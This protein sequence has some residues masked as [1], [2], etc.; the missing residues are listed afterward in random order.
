MAQLG[1]N[2][3]ATIEYALRWSDDGVLFEDRY[4]ARR[5]NV[6]RDIFPTGLEEKLSGCRVDDSIC[7]DYGPGQL[8]PPAREA[9]VM[10]LPF[11]DFQQRTISGRRVTPRL[12][13]FYPQ[14]M[15]QGV[16]GVFPGTTAPFRI[17]EMDD[18]GIVAD[19]N[20]PLARYSLRLEARVLQLED[21]SSETGGRLSHWVEELCNWGPG[22]QAHLPGAATD[23]VDEAF[24]D[25]IDT[26]ADSVFYRDPRFI[27]H[28]DSQASANLQAIYSRDLRP[29]MRVLDLMSSVESHLPMETDIVVTGLGLNG[30]EMSE[31]PRLSRYIVHD[32]N[33]DASTLLQPS[34]YEAVVC[35]LS[36]EYLKHP[37]AV[38]KNIHDIL[39]PG[40]VLLVGLSNRWFPTKVIS[41]W[42]DLHEFERVGYVLDCMRRAGFTCKEAVSMRNDWR[43]P[44][45]DHFV[46]T[47]GVSDPVYVIRAQKAV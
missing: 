19:C 35:S 33:T 31:N 30:L 39:V 29:G 10:R 13:R 47:R 43:P 3:L 21:K 44:W 18:R 9:N 12:G 25:R 46:E 40:G 4:L 17:V 37:V 6:W 32:L 26:A 15:L 23:F 2:S 20:H 36:F 45:D 1:K 11:E 7:C 38:L 8:V 14:G 34:G 16:L 5:V 41:G 42:I 24:F 27:G 22:M 28:V